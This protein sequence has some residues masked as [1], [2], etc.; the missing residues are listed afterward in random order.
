MAYVTSEFSEPD[1]PISLMVR[2]KA[3]PGRVVSLPF[4]EQRYYKP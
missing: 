3:L 1:T 2:G 4:V